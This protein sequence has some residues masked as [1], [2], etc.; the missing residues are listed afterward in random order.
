MPDSKSSTIEKKPP[1]TN[2][3]TLTLTNNDKKGSNKR[4]IAKKMRSTFKTQVIDRPQFQGITI[5]NNVN[6]D[7]FISCART[8]LD[9]FLMENVTFV[10]RALMKEKRIEVPFL[11]DQDESVHDC[12]SFLSF[13]LYQS[14]FS[15]LPTVVMFRNIQ[16]NALFCLGA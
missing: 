6:N 11:F 10:V 1:F 7:L 9:T 8:D 16:A 15:C 12:L 2:V 13:C 5:I 4:L 3:N 14:N